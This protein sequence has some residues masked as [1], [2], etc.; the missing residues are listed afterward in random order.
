MCDTAAAG[1]C[2]LSAPVYCDTYR[3]ALTVPSTMVITSTWYHRLDSES[4]VDTICV[5]VEDYH[6]DFLHLRVKHFQRLM[7]MIHEQIIVSY[8]RQLLSPSRY[9]SPNFL[10]ISKPS[11]I[12]TVAKL[13]SFIDMD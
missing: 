13:L 7:L 6:Q 3:G 5:T 10:E 8:L 12:Y 1:C 4:D 2:P 9:A 11:F